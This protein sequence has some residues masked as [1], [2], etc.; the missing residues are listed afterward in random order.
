MPSVANAMRSLSNN[1]DILENPMKT[2]FRLA[3]GRTEVLVVLVKFQIDK[4]TSENFHEER[5]AHPIL[6]LWN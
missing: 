3:E 2:I 5:T 6:R 1:L 4:R